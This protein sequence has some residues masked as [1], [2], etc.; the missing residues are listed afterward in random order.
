MSTI[1][2]IREAELEFAP[3]VD[4]ADIYVVNINRDVALNGT[5]PSFPQ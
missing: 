4:D 3:L 1:K 2:D 5:V